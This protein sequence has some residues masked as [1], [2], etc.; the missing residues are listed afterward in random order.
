MSRRTSTRIAD[1]YRI[2]VCKLVTS[3]QRKLSSVRITGNST[4]VCR[5]AGNSLAI[6]YVASL[7][8]DDFRRIGC[9]CQSAFVEDPLRRNEEQDNRFHESKRCASGETSFYFAYSS[10]TPRS[11][12]LA[13]HEHGEVLHTISTL[14]L[15]RL[16]LVHREIPMV[17]VKGTHACIRKS[18]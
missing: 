13:W 18:T 15:S 12:S 4:V 14:Q 16:K 9:A 8:L 17:Q 10:P 11:S 2:D 7:K 1:R 5:P 6:L 3:R